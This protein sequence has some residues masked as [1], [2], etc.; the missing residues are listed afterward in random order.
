MH[1]SPNLG[2]P[3]T[4]VNY[5]RKLLV[6]FSC[7]NLC[8]QIASSGASARVYNKSFVMAS[9]EE[10]TAAVAFALSRSTWCILVQPDSLRRR[11]ESGKTALERS[12]L[13]TPSCR[14]SAGGGGGGG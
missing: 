1:H 7:V 2:N 9:K 6:I 11:R 14:E 3:V 8:A 4:S 5:I 12:V 10:F 13:D